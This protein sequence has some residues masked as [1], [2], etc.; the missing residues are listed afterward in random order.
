MVPYHKRNERLK[1]G[2]DIIVMI[3]TLLIDI[4]YKHKKKR[5]LNCNSK[6]T[7][8]I[9]RSNKSLI[10]YSFVQSSFINSYTF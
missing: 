6:V 9:Y 2:F 8:H 5:D 10:N 7:F 1:M 3:R 4:I